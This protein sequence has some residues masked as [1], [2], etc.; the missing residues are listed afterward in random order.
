M[1]GRYSYCLYLIHLPVMWT[2]R[3]LVFDPARAPVV[4]G[5]ALPAQLLFWPLAILPA[6]ALAWLSWRALEEPFQRLKRYF[7]Y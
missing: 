7:S 1:F 6:L 3:S 5:S 2:M 4:M